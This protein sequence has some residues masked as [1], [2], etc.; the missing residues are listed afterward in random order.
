MWSH[1][2]LYS[3]VISLQEW[4][5]SH[6]ISKQNMKK[7]MAVRKQLKQICSSNLQL[8]FC[9]CDNSDSIRWALVI[10]YIS[11]HGNCNRLCMVYG[12][13]M[14]VAQH[15]Q[16]G[17][18][19]TVSY[20]CYGITCYHGNVVVNTSTSIY[21]SFVLFVSL[22][23]ISKAVVVYWSCLHIKMLHEVWICCH[24]YCK[25]VLHLTELYLLLNQNG[26]YK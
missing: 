5:N 17:C 19:Q 25:Y 12:F 2:A 4:C 15:S 22:P 3:H 24:S 8:S 26:C 21:T 9:H 20:F 18:Y 14:N 10:Y 7:V 11:H 6:F 23:T 16:D 1:Y 13:F